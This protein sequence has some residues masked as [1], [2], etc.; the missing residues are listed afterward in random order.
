MV[1][2]RAWLERERLD[3]VLLS[4]R[5]SFAWATAGGDNHVSSATETGVADLWV[6]QDRAILLANNI[7][8]G[9]IDEEELEGLAVD[10]FAW[11][12]YKEAEAEIRRFIDGRIAA[13]DTPKA[14]LSDRR[15]AL[16]ELRY[17]LT[18]YEVSRYRE[19]GRQA[20][21]AVESVAERVK[22]RE[23]EYQVAAALNAA[24]LERGLEP[25]VTLIAADGR[26]ERYRHP[27][28]T[29]ARIQR[30]A[31]LVSCARK[32]GLIASLTRIVH[33]G[34]PSTDLQ[35][36]HAAVT[37]VDAALMRMTRPG[38]SGAELFDAITQLYAQV[39]YPGEWELHHQGGAT[40]YA[41]REWRATPGESRRVVENQAFAWNPSITGTK[42]EDTII[43][44]A[45][46]FEVLTRS[47]GRWP[48]RVV[49]VEGALIE[50]PDI[51]SL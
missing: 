42:S 35:E 6:D 17:E 43:V 41:G 30:A 49:E 46:G 33:F 40:G 20:A 9:R 8:A 14:G 32:G 16:A 13:G 29:Q 18:P 44:D 10:I 2:L 36:R 47:P 50:R 5:D 25:V 21:E 26:I 31:M 15:G 19:L 3:G 24:L 7:E 12:W 48:M 23:S 51:L 39:G 1:R 45:A 34:R 11:P 22:L 28:P 37:Q 4:R 38:M 27:I